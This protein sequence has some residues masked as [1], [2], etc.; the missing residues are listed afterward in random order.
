M[1]CRPA[2]NATR[3]DAALCRLSDPRDAPRPQEYPILFV[4]F[5]AMTL[6]LLGT[7]VVGG[8]HTLLWIPRSLAWRREVKEALAAEERSAAA[9]AAGKTPGGKA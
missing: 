7:L 5:W 2:R 1:S 4:V 3:G 8:L 9:A 6:L